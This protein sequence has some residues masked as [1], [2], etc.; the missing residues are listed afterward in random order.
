VELRFE[1]NR[2]N[3]L[4]QLK[5]FMLE[6]EKNF[7][8]EVFLL[9]N[10]C[11]TMYTKEYFD[12]HFTKKGDNWLHSYRVSL[13]YAWHLLLF[14]TDMERAE[15]ILKK[16]LKD[17]Q[18]KN[19]KSKDYGELFWFM[20]EKHIRDRNGNFFNGSILLLI[21][22][23]EKEKL[24]PETKRDLLKTLERLYPVFE[25]ERAKASLT[26]V[27][28]A[29]GKFSMC[30]LLAELFKKKS[31]NEDKK[32]LLAYLRFLENNGNNESLSPTYISVDISILL[33][34]SL[35]SKDK[36]VKT[37]IN[38]VLKEVFFREAEFFGERFPAPFR[39][40]Y[41]GECAVY[42]DD[43][44]PALLG[45]CEF[46]PKQAHKDPYLTIV[47][48]LLFYITFDPKHKIPK[49]TKQRK[50]PREMKGKIFKDCES[51]SYLSSKYLMGSIN[52]YP[53]ETTCWQCVT[54]GGSGWQDGLAYLTFCNSDETA[55]ILRLEATDENGNEKTHPYNGEFNFDKIHRLYP[56]ISFPPE[57]EIRSLQNK[58]SLLC[59]YKVDM[60]D[61]SLRKFGFNMHFQRFNGTI[62]SIEGKKIAN[63]KSK[64]PECV[65]LEEENT[66]LA[67]FPLSRV[68]MSGS[69]LASGKFIE[70]SVDMEKKKS[71][72]NLKMYNCDGK[73]QRYT[74]NHISGGFFIFLKEKQEINSL[75]DFLRLAKAIKINEK[76][77][78]DR[79]NAHIDKRDSIREV[80]VTLPDQELKL[81]WDHYNNAETVRRTRKI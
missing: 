14:E 10:Q 70:P 36:E 45:Y 22:S 55:A 21:Y 48:A 30:F 29:L 73:A 15:L 1:M 33:M 13:A 26:Y 50:L 11:R 18:E 12:L 40:G 63:K 20:E 25:R 8:N 46:K 51:Y 41:N 67:F 49:I 65:V 47:C 54:T 32:F 23:L 61:A 31:L 7:D 28:P 17:G 9:G 4:A 57:P 60:L 35:L 66:F 59:L 16:F 71:D 3:I 72:L 69:S 42:R 5:P 43:I 56:F 52:Y 24:K 68:N 37:A 19:K 75:K 78:P 81:G 38:K 79:M 34:A 58:N 64:I 74:Q 6:L 76:W 80:T 62:Y 53:P 2:K 39:R 27:N 77:T 44:L